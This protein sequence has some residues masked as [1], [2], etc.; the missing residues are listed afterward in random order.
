M[1][2]PA[3]EEM[4]KEMT[5]VEFVKV[6]VDVADEV[7]SECGIQAMPTFQFFKG[8]KKVSEVRGADIAKL[9]AVIAANK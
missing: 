2:A 4:S 7:A 6:N 9:K 1:V 5:D 8:G 3:Y